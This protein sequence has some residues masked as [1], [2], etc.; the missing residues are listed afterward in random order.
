MTGPAMI[1]I[2]GG[3]WL[4]AVA[5]VCAIEAAA[6]VWSYRR[7]PQMSGAH[8][9]AFALKVLGIL[10]VGL[11]LAEPL[12]SGRRVEPGANVLVVAA[13]NSGSMGV[14]DEGAAQIRGEVMADVL[15]GDGAGW[16]ARLDEDFQVRRYV[17]DS[18][19]RR[20]T[21]FSELTFD[22]RG[23]A[24]ATVLRLAGSAHGMGL[25]PM[26]HRQDADATSIHGQDARATQ[27]QDALATDGG[28]PVA[29]IVLLT[30]GVATDIGEEF[31][32]LSGVPP[33]YPVVVGGGRLQRDLAL[34]NV[35]VTQTAFEDAP[36]TIQADVEAAGFAGRDVVVAVL[37]SNAVEVQRSE[38]KVKGDDDRQVFRFAIRP[39]GSGVLFYRVA[40][41]EGP[42]DEGR[43]TTD[44]LMRGRD[45]RDTQGQDALATGEATMLNNER[46]VVV[47]RRRGPYRI[48][49]VSGRPNWEY[50]FLKRALEADE[51]VQLVGLLRVARREPKYDWRGRRGEQSN[52][53]YRGYDEREQA[54]AESYDQPV[55][56]RLNT[57]DDAELADGFPKTAEALFEYHAIILDDVEKNFFTQDQMELVRRFVAERG[58][59]FAMLGGMESLREGGYD[60]TAIGGILPVYLDRV[61]E[62]PPA[63]PVRMAL[64]RE[65]W[66][67]PWV[68]LRDNEL[69]ERRRMEEMPGFEVLNR[70]G[71][72][73]AGA[74]VVATASPQ[75]GVGFDGGTSWTSTGRMPVPRQ[76]E[77]VPALVV[78]RYG[79]GR[80]AVL[81]VGDLWRWGLRS[82][83][84]RED[85]DKFWRQMARFLVA[86]VPRRFEV[87]VVPR[88]ELANQPV[89]LRVRTRG[90][91][92][93]PLDDVSVTVEVRDPRGRTLQLRA[94]PSLSE[95]GLFE[96]G[97]VPGDSGGYFARAGVRDAG[98]IE[99]GSAETGWTVDL[100]ARE[101]ASIH[102]NRALL[103]RIARA[104]G[105]R[106]VE[107]DELDKFAA[108]L[109]TR[110]APMTAVW[111]RPLWDL[112]G[113]LGGVFVAIIACFAGEW[114][115][116][117]WKQTP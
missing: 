109:P 106:M 105:G 46:T 90:K 115:L 5:A 117:R 114:L 49:Y 81:T 36:V 38:W 39:R 12:Y 63:R 33:V 68:R 98:G 97:Y 77:V 113:V 73:K 86:D 104:T 95:R 11:C 2:A 111:V 43:G 44:G 30:D 116:R 28:R 23:S 25:K 76:G 52:P 20:S 21:D 3:A 101:F 48:L 110:E 56:V 66:L 47:D 26:A 29:G 74:R 93:G 80:A 53:L 24:I 51:Q 8:R 50:K 59:G 7:V 65:G 91:D 57:R 19:V 22:G 79:N 70:V 64:T 54:E 15:A 85:M 31:Y 10:L 82:A 16:L 55:L 99:I 58:G 62:A 83:E 92:F 102:V 89:E 41:R 75:G 84:M 27:G 107:L 100:Q 88:P 69:D 60:R 67:E 6:V 1:T 37:D 108:R 40:V 17:F 87:Q 78:H 42:M 72:I 9:A 61:L 18:R 45:A 35:S 96:V 14:R 34:T 94:A 4:W 103:E 32:D 112:P 13:D 71:A